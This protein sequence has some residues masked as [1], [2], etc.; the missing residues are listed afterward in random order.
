MNRQESPEAVEIKQSRAVSDILED[1]EK[2]SNHNLQQ[3]NEYWGG[4]EYSL[5]IINSHI[6]LLIITWPC[7][8]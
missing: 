3:M 7:R 2:S 4:V 5:S 6:M 1:G 8:N